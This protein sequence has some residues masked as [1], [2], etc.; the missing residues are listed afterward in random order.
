MSFATLA[1]DC[2]GL[3]VDLAKS[4][5]FAMSRGAKELFH[6]NF[7]AFILEFEADA[8]SPNERQTITV[9]QRNLIELLFGKDNAPARVL[10]WRE[11]KSIDLIVCAA[12]ISGKTVTVPELAVRQPSK[13][14]TRTPRG[15]TCKADVGLAAVVLEAKLK[16]IPSSAQL[17][18]YTEAIGKGIG[19]EFTDPI[20][21]Q[22][23]DGQ[24]DV[25]LWGSM[26]IRAAKN[27]PTVNSA[28]LVN[29]NPD[30][31]K[32]DMPV[33]F[34]AYDISPRTDPN[35]TDSEPEDNPTSGSRKGCRN[36]GRAAGKIR[37]ILLAPTDTAAAARAAGW[38]HISW[39]ELLQAFP[40]DEVAPPA[41]G[42]LVVELLRD[43]R[44]STSKV[45][46]ILDKVDKATAAFAAHSNNAKFSVLV[47]ATMDPAF[48]Q[49]RIH[50]LVG[51]YAFD[52]L[53]FK[54]VEKIAPTAEV[55]GFQFRSEAFMSNATPG[56]IFEYVLDSSA[57]K[58]T[59]SVHVGVQLQGSIYR[60]F[61]AA[62]HPA[63]RDDESLGNLAALMGKSDDDATWWHVDNSDKGLPNQK[64]EF[65][66]FNENAF[67]YTAADVSSLTFI[68]L[69]KLLASSLARLRDK[70][71]ESPDFVTS[72]KSLHLAK[73][74]AVRSSS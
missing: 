55:S 51:K 13:F 67:L 20:E 6:T 39:R 41:A 27:Q 38:E 60:H 47:K 18:R 72:A 52:L 16:S 36:I 32:S 19:L 28:A 14:A 54:L 15:S 48:R 11:R 64:A 40:C 31:R 70:L 68:G 4:P 30:D 37:K 21:L 33:E 73:D 74:K 50:D 61:I 46:D 29:N 7:L 17:K 12:P 8:A 63:D 10:A 34:W 23:P 42:G 35:G 26:A 1:T 62:T 3:L 58:G 25:Q 44:H 5:T 57:K 24:K 45:L 22:Q 59:R 65:G 56:A 2:A 69:Q 43:Y 53:R 49:K 9:L 66:V 71:S